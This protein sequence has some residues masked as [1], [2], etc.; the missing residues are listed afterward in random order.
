MIVCKV[1]NSGYN[2]NLRPGLLYSTLKYYI[3][4]SSKFNG[5]IVLIMLPSIKKLC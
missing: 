2:Q 3:E 4:N 1:I 5:L